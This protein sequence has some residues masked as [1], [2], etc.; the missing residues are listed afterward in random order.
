VVLVDP[1]GDAVS[2]ISVQQS[3]DAPEAPTGTGDFRWIE[4]STNIEYRWDAT[5]SRWVEFRPIV[6]TTDQGVSITAT[7]GV[8]LFA[9][10]PAV[11]TEFVIS[12]LRVSGQGLGTATDY[13]NFFP[14]VFRVASGTRTDLTDYTV[15]NLT[16][17]DTNFNT[18]S[19]SDRQ[20]FTIASQ[21]THI[22]I[23]AQKI[24]NAANFGNA[25]FALQVHRVRIATA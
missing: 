25:G 19:R 10:P 8:A 14:G 12:G 22:V 15:D 23:R 3:N 4:S 7:A 20:L 6:L 21:P 11:N 2:L 1:A 17:T 18:V 9:V 16:F 24:A 13:Y 5:L